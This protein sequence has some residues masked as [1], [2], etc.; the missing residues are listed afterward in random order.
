MNLFLSL[1]LRNV[2]RNRLRTILA[3]L[4]IAIGCAALILNGGIVVN[5]FR[6]LQEDAIRGRIGHLQIYANG[7]S[8]KHLQT[9]ERYLISAGA[10]SRILQLVRSNPRVLRAT[11]RRE[12]SGLL[13]N[14]ERSVPFLGVGVEPQDDAEFSRHTTLRAGEPLSAEKPYSVLAG[15]GLAKKLNIQP[16]DTL[17]LMT[18]TESGVLNSM[19]VRL[20]GVFEGGMKEFDDWTLKVPLSLV[21]ELLGDDRTE[22]IVLLLSRTEDVPL[23]RSELQAT[24]QRDQLDL[25]LRSWDQLAVFHNQVVGLFGRELGIIRLI[26]G[27]IVILGISNVIGMALLERRLELA[28]FRALGVRARNIS[29]LLMTESL[30]IG[31]LGAGAGMLLGVGMA[32]VASAIGIS[33]PSPPGA[34]RPFVGGVD[35]TP[36]MVLAAATI[37]V[38]AA[39]AAAIIPI[40]KAVR[41]PIASTLRHS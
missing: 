40:W 6:E 30:L 35:V 25:E 4:A 33:Y 5:I 17:N 7:Y 29:V 18:T 1:A 9:P 37:S 8:E 22:Q 39:L 10:T 15:L 24:F 19:H 26:V 31:L 16:G 23:V 11:R 2:F 21:E 27:A 14:N 20:A 38:F 12:F 3:L 32:K 13:S 34:T 41:A 36:G 28:T